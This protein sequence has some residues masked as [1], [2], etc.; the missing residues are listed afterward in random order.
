MKHLFILISFIAIG[1]LSHAQKKPL[2]H[3]VYDGW[4]S[5]GERKISKN[6]NWILYSINLQEG[7]DTLV[8]QSTDNKTKK[9]IDRGFGAMFSENNQFVIFRI[10]PLY[11]EIREAKIKKK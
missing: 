1:L 5:I 2:D 8:V 9:I 7:D 6:G 4:Q 3:D 10:K 11:N